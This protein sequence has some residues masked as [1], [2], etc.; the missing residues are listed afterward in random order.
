M[1]GNIHPK[2]NQMSKILCVLYPDPVSG[3]P[4]SYA[5]DTLPVIESYPDDTPYPSELWLDMDRSGRP[6]HVVLADSHEEGQT[7]IITVYH[8][9][10]ALWQPDWTTRRNRP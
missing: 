9:D 7:I 10:P 6:L 3:Y 5:R 1:N 4:R 2:K 8:P